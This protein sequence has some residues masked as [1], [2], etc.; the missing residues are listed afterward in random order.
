MRTSALRRTLIAASLLTASSLT[1]M[2]CSGGTQADES[3]ADAATVTIQTNLGEVDVPVDPKRVAALDNTS[4][5]T[6]KALG[7]VPVAVPKPLLPNEGFEEWADDAEI[8]DAGS[9]READLEAVS[10]AEPDLI[11]GGYRFTDYQDD[12][13]KIGTT[14]D[15]APN[16]ETGYI[17]GL[18]TQTVALGQIFGKED[19]AA[20]IVDAL[21]AAIAEASAA[22]TGQSVFLAVASGGKIDNGASRIGRLL[23]ELDLENVLAAEDQSETAVHNDSGLAPETIAQLNPEWVIVLDRDAAVETEFTPAKQ[24]IEGNEA[25]AGTTFVTEGNIIYLAP[26][27]YVTEGIQAYTDAFDQVAVAIGS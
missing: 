10:E 27:F 13:E 24:L 16:D 6:I 23:E 17:E 19:E 20:E 3:A 5:A 14:I 22:T 4:F 25:F 26:D 11:I 21:D 15:I 12:L 2:G 7:I 8:L 9:H 18:K 1:L